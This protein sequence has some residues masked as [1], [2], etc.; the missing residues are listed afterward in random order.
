MMSRWSRG[1]VWTAMVVA[2]FVVGLLASGCGSRESE[3]LSFSGL[4]EEMA[5]LDRLGGELSW[6]THLASSYDRSGG[7]ED[8]GQFERILPNGRKLV[9]DA[10]GPGCV[11]RLWGTG[12]SA[13]DRLLFFFDGED[14]PRINASLRDLIYWQK[15]FPFVAPF[16]PDGSAVTYFPLPF[17]KSLRIEAEGPKPIYYQVTWRKFPKTTVVETYPGSFSHEQTNMI[18]AAGERWAAEP[19]SGGGAELE[20]HCQE[21]CVP[22]GF[23]GRLDV[24]GAGTIRKL[25]VELSHPDDPRII[26]HNIALR[27]T[28]LR[29]TWD[30]HRSPSVD[31]PLGPFFCNAWRLSS[32]DSQPM[33]ASNG[34]FVC[35]F[36]MP[37]KTGASVELKNAGLSQITVTLRAAVD[38]APVDFGDARYFHANW[39]SSQASGVEARPHTVL[40]LRGRGHYVGCSLNV[41]SGQQGWL[42]LEG[43]ETIRVDGEKTPS[44]FGTGLEDYFN[45]CWYYLHGL[46]SHRW[47]GLLEFVPYRCHQYRFH[48]VDA[49]PFRKSFHL[50]FERGDAN[51]IPARFESVAYWYADRP[52]AVPAFSPSAVGLESCGV[53]EGEAMAALFSLER[54]SRYQDAARLCRQFVQDHPKSAFR[55]AMVARRGFYEA[56]SRGGG[57][58]APVKALGAGLTRNLREQVE[59]VMA[60]NSQRAHALVGFQSSTKSRLY[61]DGTVVADVEN[62]LDYVGKVMKIGQGRHTLAMEVDPSGGERWVLATVGSP[63][64]VLG[65]ADDP[66]F[67]DSGWH[68]YYQKP[69]GWPQPS[70]AIPAVQAVNTWPGS[71]LPRPPYVAFRPGPI[72]N[73]QAGR[74]M[75]IGADPNQRS[76]RVYLTK[77]FEWPGEISLP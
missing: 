36:P 37:F 15:Q 74:V 20:W 61:L 26:H 32:F 24:P 25:V 21:V 45:D 17:Q 57:E 12:M 65:G 53:S 76:R 18:V 55:E 69:E 50:T 10:K 66:A 52:H 39:T 63:W 4:L 8:K 46:R 9:L 41:E 14:T 51:K 35:R 34:T 68:A 29:M 64:Y 28:Q 43:D 3:R 77:T 72:P 67:Y 48:N 49:I 58:A 31:V 6:K 13:D 59:A 60:L 73:M 22:V 42:V 40:D 19:S 70:G 71:G 16:R 2:V 54:A 30:E 44:H 47:H 56:L 33:S 1:V 75:L 11:Q 62:H 23:S 38:R 7:N 5:S 27:R